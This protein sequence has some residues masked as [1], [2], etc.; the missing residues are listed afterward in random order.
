MD[1]NVFIILNIPSLFLK[2]KMLIEDRGLVGNFSHTNRASLTPFYD[3]HEN[4][5]SFFVSVDVNLP[6]TKP[7]V[8]KLGSI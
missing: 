8:S 5:L 4:S 6:E 7:G 2:N 1:T 3:L